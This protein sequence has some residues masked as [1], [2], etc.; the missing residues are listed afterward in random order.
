MP[1]KLPPHHLVAL[2]ASENDRVRASARTA[3]AHGGETARAALQRGL[4]HQDA[5]AARICADLLRS[6]DRATSTPKAPARLP[7]VARALNALGAKITRAARPGSVQ[8]G[9]ELPSR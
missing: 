4:A 5:R 6:L 2:L 8:G 1:P 9:G 3:L 7:R